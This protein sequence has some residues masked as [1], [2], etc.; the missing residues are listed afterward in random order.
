[1]SSKQ[2]KVLIVDDSTI[3]LERLSGL[4]SEIPFLG[5]VLISNSFNHAVD[6]INV[7]L[8][9]VVLLDIQL[10]GKSGIELL[11]FIKS[12]YPQIKTLIVTNRVSAYYKRLCK[13]LGAD[14][15]IDKSTEFEKIPGIIET[16]CK[17][18]VSP[19]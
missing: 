12:K 6:L 9:K 16:F 1:M 2:F 7:E 10:D 8:P 3:V 11:G 19:A 17:N 5:P 4:I 18:E 13:Q 14:G 15:F